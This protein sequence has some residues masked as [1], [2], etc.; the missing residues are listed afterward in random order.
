MV[1]A[2][3]AEAEVTHPAQGRCSALCLLDLDTMNTSC[4]AQCLVSPQRAY[5]PLAQLRRRNSISSACAQ[6][7]R[8]LSITRRSLILTVKANGSAPENSNGT[9][10]S[11]GALKFLGLRDGA[12]SEEMVRARNKMLSRY[13]N[14]DEKRQKVEA[15][16]DVLL[17]QSLMRRSKGEVVDSS[18]K[19]A[20][21]LKPQ[22]ALSQNFPPW[23]KDI[24]KALPPRPAVEVPEDDSVKTS[25]A[26]FGALAAWTLAQGAMQAPGVNDAPG[27]QLAVGLG[28][29]VWMLQKKNITI[30]RSVL[31][32]VLGL[33][34]GSI[35]GGIV[36]GWLRVDIVPLGPLSSPSALA[37]EFSL[38]GMFCASTFLF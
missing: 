11:Q 10:D 18:V 7:S 2:H 35:A 4:T 9:M 33:V 32:A 25:A 3:G 21:V 36:Q 12:S 13:E 22:A 20:D 26:V 19:Y 24:A 28:A 30:G 37:S 6:R 38:L 14:D 15:A 31:L 16:Y 23:L 27:L 17:M 5:V 1:H 34:V 29:S 8:S